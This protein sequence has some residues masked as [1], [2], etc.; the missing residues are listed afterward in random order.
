MSTLNRTNGGIAVAT[1]GAATLNNRHGQV[2]SEALTTAAAATYV[3]TLT[4]SAVK[5]G[6]NVQAM[7]MYGDSTTGEPVVTR[8]AVTAGQIV[9]SVKNVAASAALNGTVKVA[10]NV[11]PN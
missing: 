4:N 5:V 2:T 6:D 7:A 11:F 9:F 1:A 10:Y 8:V 3:L